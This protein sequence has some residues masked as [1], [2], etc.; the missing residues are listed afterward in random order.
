MALQRLVENYRIA[1]PRIADMLENR[2]RGAERLRWT[3]MFDKLRRTAQFANS[4]PDA[5]FSG[6]QAPFTRNPSD[7]L[8]PDEFFREFN[9]AQ[10]M[11][12]TV[13]PGENFMDYLLGRKSNSMA[14]TPKAPAY[15]QPFPNIF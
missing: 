15:G 9:S 13:R 3:G 11:F 5:F 6:E 12:N 14:S 2:V 4:N 10:Q 8:N 1:D 7:S